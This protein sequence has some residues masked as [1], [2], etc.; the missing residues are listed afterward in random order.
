MPEATVSPLMRI[1]NPDSLIYKLDLSEYEGAKRFIAGYANVAGIKDSQDEIVTLEALTNAWSRWRQNPEY[2]ILNLL[3]SNVP[4]AKVIFETVVDSEGNPHRSG[5]DDKGLYIVAQVRDDVTLAD[6]IWEKIQ[7]GE[8]RGFS[9]GGRNLAPQPEQCEGDRCIRPITNLELYEVSIVDQPANR[10][11]IFTTLKSDDALSKINEAT[12]GFRERILLGGAVKIS[13]TRGESCGKYHVLL[14]PNFSVAMDEFETDDTRVAEKPM[15]GMEYISLFD[16]A[17]LRPQGALP[18]EETGHGGFNPSPPKKE[19]PKDEEELN[20]LSE[21]NIS[22][23]VEISETTGG[24]EMEAIAPI[25][26][27]TLAADL[28]RVI[29]RLEGL[30]KS[31]GKTEKVEK[32]AEPV[33]TPEESPEVKPEVDI[34]ALQRRIAELEKLVKEKPIPEPT[35]EPKAVEKPEPVEEKTEKVEP[36]PEPKSEPQAEPPKAEKIET[37]GVAVQ[38]IE[39]LT[40]TSIASL[41]AVSWRDIQEARDKLRK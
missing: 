41:T 18:A 21:D 40:G 36:E 11:S 7:R 26:L 39:E 19:E 6:E 9:I 24:E 30:E 38:A 25:T 2:C 14:C 27:E 31:Q 8:Y 35:P 15:E 13:R 37:R 28:A 34:E 32:S 12:K 23:E 22:A 33:E 17:L 4:L 5:V 29:E 10:V 3:H 1:I 16:L 20:P